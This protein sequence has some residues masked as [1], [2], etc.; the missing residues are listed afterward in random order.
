ML[1]EK[2]QF[3]ICV[4]TSRLNLGVNLVCSACCGIRVSSVF[5]LSFLGPLDSSLRFARFGEGLTQQVINYKCRLTA[6]GCMATPSGQ[7]SENHMGGTYR[8]LSIAGKGW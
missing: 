1:G 8:D 7:A 3:R 6:T 2:N 5:L 4:V